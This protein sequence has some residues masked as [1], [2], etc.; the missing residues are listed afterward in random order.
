MKKLL[1]LLLVL[2]I[3]I[4]ALA[5]CS[6][7]EGILGSSDSSSGGHRPDVYRYNDFTNEEKEILTEYVGEVIPFVPCNK[8]YFEGIYD[9]YSFDD[10][11]NYYTV[12]ST[13]ADF[14]KYVSLYSEYEYT[15]S[16]T[17]D[18]GDTWY[19]YENDKVTVNLSY[20]FYSG[21]SYIDVLA[22]P[23]T[24]L[25]DD[26]GGGNTDS[27]NT[28]GGNTDNGNTDSGNTDSGNTDSGNT[29]GN[30]TDSGNTGS[31]NTDSENTGSGNTG[32]GNTDSGN[33]G[34]NNTD[35]AGY[36]VVDFTRA[37]KVKDITDQGSY[38]G[39]CPTTGSPKVL[40]IPVEFSDETAASNGYTIDAIEEAWIGNS[41]TVDYYSVH[42]YYYISS[43]GQLDLDIT[44]V[45]NWFRPSHPSS[46]YANQTVDF[47]D[48]EDVFIG[49][50]IV[51]DEALEALSKTM[52]LSEFDSDNNGM[53]DAV[54]IIN[55]LDIDSD[56]DFQWAFRYWNMYTDSNDE[57]YEY[58][59]V[60]ANDYVWASYKFMHEIYT[61]DG[62]VEYTG[63]TP[64]N[65]YTYI[66]EF[67]HALGADD[68]YDTTGDASPMGGYDVMDYMI[69]DHNAYTKFNYGWITTSKL[70]TT[71][72]SATITLEAFEKNGDTIIL[73]NN[74]ND[75]LGA[76]QEYYVIVYYT[77]SG[78][79]GGEFGYFSS[80]GIIVYHVNA[81]LDEYTYQG[82]TYY[83][84]ANTNSTPT[85]SYDS[86]DNLIEFV[87]NGANYV[88]QV[89]ATLSTVRDDN[90]RT[91][92]YTFRV[93]SL[94]G[95][96]ATI[97][98]TKR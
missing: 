44:V 6:V 48:E 73:A 76:Y 87:K 91:L 60:S 92:G 59:G 50:Q 34:G 66:H 58:D 97:T 24:D 20:Y 77:M 42:D 84:V 61:D 8:Y 1:S 71:T 4:S 90:N 49:D 65:T 15:G 52:D 72:T 11:V 14:E 46:Y 36:R 70:V 13:R 64:S 5:S 67:G 2:F 31:G 27:G 78:L 39:G 94:D 95:D 86:S 43:Y 74:W 51:M 47:Y 19:T 33:T 22:Y 21:A 35:S 12:G 40:V 17:D 57:Y 41:E 30:N 82:E 96:T 29:G 88:Y 9:E 89:G 25:D 53:I 98:F 18:Y 55:T 23:R 26:I 38:I 56:T 16:Y 68:Y 75:N 69:G 32:G 10:G 79:N 63:A 80:D 93:D 81:T 45:D 62:G 85:S 37:T 3:S 28:D 83:D 54:V 7:V